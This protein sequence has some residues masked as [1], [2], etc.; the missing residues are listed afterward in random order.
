MSFDKERSDDRY[1]FKLVI[2]Y[3]SDDPIFLYV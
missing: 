3:L 1:V 2:C